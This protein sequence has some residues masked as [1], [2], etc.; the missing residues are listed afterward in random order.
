[1]I[2]KCSVYTSR[3]V[4]YIHIEKNLF[5][6]GNDCMRMHGNNQRSTQFEGYNNIL[7]IIGAYHRYILIPDIFLFS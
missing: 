4:Y 6:G 7:I 1:M 2:I 5:G 3:S